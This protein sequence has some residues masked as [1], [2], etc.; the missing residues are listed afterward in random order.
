MLPRRP[1]HPLH[2]LRLAPLALL[3]L[4]LA[5]CTA[6]LG[7]RLDDPTPIV[8]GPL[9][10]RNQHPVS[11]TFLHMRPRRAA[12]TAPGRTEVTLTGTYTSIYEV[13]S[14]P[15][16]A[17]DFD[18]EL[19]HT[20]VGV[21]RGIAEGTDLEVDLALTFATGGF[22]DPVVDRFH[23]LFHL[24]NQGRDEAESDQFRMRLRRH[25]QEIYDLEE[26]RVGFGDVPIVLAHRLR[27]EDERG[28]A[29]AL[30]AGIELP[31]GSAER[32]FGNGELDYGAGLLAERSLGRWTWTGA[33]DVTATGQPD[34][35]SR[36]GVEANDLLHVQA[37]AEYRWSDRL[38]LL[39]QVF[40]TSPMTDDYD[41]EEFN[42]EIVDL[43]VGAAWGRP[44]GPRWFCAFQEDVVAAT[45]PDF[46]FLLGASWGF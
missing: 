10:T 39:V 20:A 43:A 37:G 25:G 12:V 15:G 1:L 40:W 31:T 8:R 19:A 29:V 28:P 36:G 21:R 6:L 7:P 32:G 44:G 18:G 46:G 4:D 23:E 9:P 26:D 35:W 14:R 24:P 42:R 3:P 34:A 33:L 27:E 30:R 45:G 16:Q 11:L 5:A 13:D 41:L 17:I 2:L 38:S 22:L